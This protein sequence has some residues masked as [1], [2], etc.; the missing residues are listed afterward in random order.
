MDETL[1]WIVVNFQQVTVTGLLA[2]IIIGRFKGWWVDGPTF[3]KCETDNATFEAQAKEHADRQASELAA[4][5]SEVASLR[6]AASRR[7]T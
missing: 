1:R 3:R 5:R 4:L 7:R 6:E 2:L